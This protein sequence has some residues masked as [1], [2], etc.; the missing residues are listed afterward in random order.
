MHIFHAKQ[1][2][3]EQELEV[4]FEFLLGS[5]KNCSSAHLFH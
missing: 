4:S 2:H 1:M 5:N 3:D